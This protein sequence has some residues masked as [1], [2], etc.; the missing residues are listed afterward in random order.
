MAGFS[1]S[2][3]AAGGPPILGPGRSV[4]GVLT[5]PDPF[6]TDIAASRAA[7]DPPGLFVMLAGILKQFHGRDTKEIFFG[8]KVHFTFDPTLS[9]P[10]D[11]IIGPS[12]ARPSEKPDPSITSGEKT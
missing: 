4:G 5:G 3:A 8:E 2:Q 1:D 7:G 12:E 6:P 11:T 10:L 9:N